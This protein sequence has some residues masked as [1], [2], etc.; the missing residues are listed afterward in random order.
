[1][2][3]KVV[4]WGVWRVEGILAVSRAIG[5]CMLKRYVSAQPDFVSCTVTD[6]D[7]YMVMAFDGLWD[8]MENDIVEL[9][10]M[11]FH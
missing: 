9:F 4:F 5:D 11:L 6:D 7:T 1:M 8:V 2:G 10:L 3:G